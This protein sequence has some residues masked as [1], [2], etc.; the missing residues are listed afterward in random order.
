MRARTRYAR[1]A[2]RLTNFAVALKQIHAG[3]SSP[4]ACG[5]GYFSVAADG[6][7]YACHRAVG[8]ERYRLGSASTLDGNRGRLFLEARL[9]RIAGSVGR[10]ICAR[11]AVIRKHRCEALRAGIS[12]AAGYDSGKAPN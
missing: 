7:W 3:A 5:G 10:V 11:A 12:F 6:D 2:I 8:D 1:T 4:Y 9:R